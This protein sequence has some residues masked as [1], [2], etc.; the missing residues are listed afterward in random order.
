MYSVLAFNLPH[1]CQAFTEIS[2]LSLAENTDVYVY[3]FYFSNQQSG[4][5]L[6]LSA[7]LKNVIV[8][9]VFF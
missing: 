5:L 6:L 2:F 9:I 7:S 3:T 8:S 1:N 4:A